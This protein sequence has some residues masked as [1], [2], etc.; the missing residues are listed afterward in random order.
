MAVGSGTV[1][2]VRQKMTADPADVVIMTDVGVDESVRQ[3]AIV[4]GVDFDDRSGLRC[5]FF[6]L[7]G[8]LA[9]CRR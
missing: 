2:G 8:A 3:G 9:G 5:R 4:A 1:G 7:R 6:P